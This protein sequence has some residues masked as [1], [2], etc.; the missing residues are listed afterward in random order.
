[1]IF[2]NNFSSINSFDQSFFATEK[3]QWVTIYI[4]FKILWQLLLISTFKQIHHLFFSLLYSS[5]IVCLWTNKH[6]AF[7]RLVFMF[8]VKNIIQKESNFLAI[9]I[10][11]H[12]IMF[13]SS[14]RLIFRKCF[15]YYRIKL[16]SKNLFAKTFS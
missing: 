11:R 3:I 14:E 13:C 16:W 2:W 15:S 10:T 8:I 6:F 1:M 4:N 7:N 9:I 5:F 12:F